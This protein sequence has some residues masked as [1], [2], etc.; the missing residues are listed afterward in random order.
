MWSWTREHKCRG[1]LKVKGGN[2][3]GGNTLHR[4]K[5]GE[6]GRE[7]KEGAF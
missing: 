4:K 6:M 1:N 7:G 3:Q 5:K 2:V